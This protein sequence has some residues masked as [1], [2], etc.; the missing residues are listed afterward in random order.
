MHKSF[1]FKGLNRSG[2]VSLA[3]D[4]ECMDVV[5]LRMNNG[6][7][8]PMPALGQ[9]AELESEYFAIYW[10]PHTKHYLCVVN[11]SERGV[12]FY[13]AEWKRVVLEFPELNGV[14][15]SACSVT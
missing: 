10:H 6:V 1:S 8:Q 12:H 11:D 3:A 2:D 14:E 7:L 13:D 9:V 4:G 15:N 5:N